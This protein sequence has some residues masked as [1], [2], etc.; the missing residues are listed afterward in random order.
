MTR[1][2]G[3]VDVFEV[4][5]PTRTSTL[6][7]ARHMT[8]AAISL[9]C[10]LASGFVTKTAFAPLSRLTIVLQVAG[11]QSAN[12]STAKA[13]SISVNFAYAELWNIVDKEGV[14]ALWRSN[15][16]SIVHK[17][18][19]TGA[20]YAVYEHVKLASRPFWSHDDNPGFAMRTACATTAACINNTIA[21]P[22]DHVRTVLAC[23]RSDSSSSRLGRRMSTTFFSILE[24]GGLRALYRGL[25]CTLLCQGP[26]I[27]LNFG[28]YETLNTQF[29]EN[30]K[31]RTGLLQSFIC[32]AVAGCTASCIV[33]PLDLIRRRQQ[34][35]S[36]KSIL[37]SCKQI[38][39]CEGFFGFYR[40]LVPELLKVAP[41][42]GLNFYIYEYFREWLHISRGS[43]IS[44]R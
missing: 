27:G 40:G 11:T 14:Y 16:T 36:G 21:Y 12:P 26:N 38:W 30:G 43:Q 31:S 24:E 22:L 44:P 4:G 32:G 3:D 35:K 29:L 42:V 15:W 10:G 33:H 9:S 2:L 8:D 6:I 17:A 25:P 23:E 19:I 34:M 37:E 28:I 39:K 5:E 20:N 1:V 7:Q 13:Q 18:V 41:A